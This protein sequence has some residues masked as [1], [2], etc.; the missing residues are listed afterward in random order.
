M[1]SLWAFVEGLQADQRTE[2]RQAL[3]Q[4][5]EI[6]KSLQE[7]ESLPKAPPVPERMQS[8]LGP[9]LQSHIADVRRIIA[10]VDQLKATVE[11][12]FEDQSALHVERVLRDS[13]KGDSIPFNIAA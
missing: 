7:L 10:D 1:E 11:S 5:F 3:Q 2:A 9:D 13:K 6:G 4:A 8:L 12:I